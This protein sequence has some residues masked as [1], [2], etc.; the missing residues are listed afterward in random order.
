MGDAERSRSALLCAG[1]AVSLLAMLPAGLSAGGTGEEAQDGLELND[2]WARETVAG[3][4]NSAAYLE[5]HNHSANDDR[6]TG[7]STPFA[8]VVEVHDQQMDNGVMR[9]VHLPDGLEVPAGETVVL[10][11]Q[12]YH[13]MIIGLGEVLEAGATVPLVLEFEHAGEIEATAEIR[14]LRESEPEHE[15]HDMEEMAE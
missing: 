5:I 13:L 12:S 14:P 9:M 7:G 11:P 6:L 10:Q 4:P 2:V 15:D 3:A 8:D 1:L